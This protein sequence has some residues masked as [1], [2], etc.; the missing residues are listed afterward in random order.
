MSSSCGIKN[1]VTRS[2]PSLD[3][4]RKKENDAKPRPFVGNLGMKSKKTCR[5]RLH[6]IKKKN[7]SG[8]PEKGSRRILTSQ[9][10]KKRERGGIRGKKKGT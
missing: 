4:K 8:Y 7:F 5:L 2:P 1:K 3:K 10:K 9:D 6:T